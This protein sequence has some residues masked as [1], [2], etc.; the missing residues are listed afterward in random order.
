[1]KLNDYFEYKGGFQKGL[2]HGFKSSITNRLTGESFFG[3]YYNS[4]KQGYGF[5]RI[6]EV[7]DYEGNFFCNLC[8]G[9]GKM[10]YEDG[11]F[12]DGNF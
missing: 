7:G 5:L 11:S 12:Y 8:S 1:M 4:Y 3:D 9:L 10:K 2:F 6:P